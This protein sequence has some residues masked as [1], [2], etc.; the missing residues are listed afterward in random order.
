MLDTRSRRFSARS[1]PAT[2]GYVTAMRYTTD[3]KIEITSV[4]NDD[5]ENRPAHFMR[6]DARTGRRLLGPVHL[7]RRAYSP[8]LLTSDGSRLITAGDGEVAVRDPETLR[9][10]R[11]YRVAGETGPR[12]ATGFALSPDDRTLS[13]GERDGTVR[14]L[15]LQTGAVRTASGRHDDGVGAAQFTPDGRTLLTG[16]EDD[17]VIVRDVAEAAAAETLVGHGNGIES[18]RISRDGRTAYTAS[19]DGT[20]FIW[21]LLGRRRLGRPFKAGG[22]GD[23]LAAA[24]SPDGRLFAKG[25]DD[26]TIAITD[27]R[28][29]ARRGSFRVGDTGDG[30]RV[31]WVPGSRLLVVS[32]GDGVEALVDSA[33][34]RV[35]RPLRGHRSPIY[36]PGISADGRLLVTGSKDN[37]V[38]F[39]SLP[40]GRPIGAPLRFPFG[41]FDTQ[42]SPDGRWVTVVLVDRRFKGGTVEVWDARSRHR[43]R[44]VHVARFPD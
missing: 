29:L 1:P 33:T 17:K 4:S 40:D 5:S 8:L 39:W 38:R 10:R 43:V 12:W 9:V 23:A 14:L 27:T 28:T 37:T 15:D 20:V 16:S 35:V 31:R 42:L 7:N 18:L 30:L 3:D 24:V 34:G 25:Q 2:G 21:D 41:L 6:Y 44:S 26:G 22:A 36:T 32:S 19:L 11:R 13:I